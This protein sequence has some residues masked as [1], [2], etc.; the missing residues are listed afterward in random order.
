MRVSLA[1]MLVRSPGLMLFD[2]PFSALDE[3]N[4]QYLN[5]LLS[6]LY[7]QDRWT[8]LFVTHSV[9][10]ALFLASRVLV[11]GGRPGYIVGDFALP[12][13]FPRTAELR[14]SSEYFRWGERLSNV[15]REARAANGEGGRP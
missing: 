13:K 14:N 15:L 7:A 2:E 11:I 1:R 8:G 4:R 12:W 5:E 10:E 3:I 9:S 6:A